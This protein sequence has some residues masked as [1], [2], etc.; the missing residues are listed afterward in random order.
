M[1]ITQYLIKCYKG[2]RTCQLTSV[3]S[4]CSI[5]SQSV[6]WGLVFGLGLVED[7]ILFLQMTKLLS[8]FFLLFLSSSRNNLLMFLSMMVISGLMFTC[9]QLVLNL[10]H[11]D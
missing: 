9:F 5:C 6:H 2:V 8:P 4:T 7:T 1:T 3:V 10:S 11:G